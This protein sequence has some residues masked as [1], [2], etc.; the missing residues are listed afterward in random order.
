MHKNA[1][2]L[3]L[4]FLWTFL[5]ISAASAAVFDRQVMSSS[6]AMEMQTQAPTGRIVVKFTEE[7][8][9]LVS[10]NGL[11]GGKPGAVQRLSNLMAKQSTRG[12][13]QRRF[14]APMAQI[15]D[16]RRAGE[17]RIK[18]PLPNLNRYAVVDLSD[19]AGD[20]TQLL[21]VLKTIL[22]DPAVETA[23]LEPR[24]VPAAL[25]FDAFTGAYNPPSIPEA[26]ATVAGADS[27]FNTGFPASTNDFSSSQG[28]LGASPEGVNAW[29]VAD[30]PGA[31]GAGLHIIDIEG[32]WVWDHEDL[33]SPF[34]NPGS[35]MSAQSWRDHGTAVLGEI[36]GLDNGFGVR[37]I[38][39][40]VAIGGISI[41][42]FSVS[43]AINAAWRA[44]NP[45]DAIVIELHAPGPYSSG[46]G[47]DGYLPMEYWQDNFDAILIATANGR[48]VCEAA[49]NGAEDL[50]AP[51]YE[52][53]FDREY[54]DS[55]AIMCGAA[56]R[57]GV[58][59][60]FTNHGARVDLN[61]WG[62][63]VTTCAYGDLQGEPS[64]PETEFY[65]AHFSGTS[66]ATPIVT[67]AVLA[68]QG[69]VKEGSDSIL[70]PILM[71]EILVLTGSPSSGTKHCGPRPDILAAW[72][73]TA[74]GFGTVSGTV[75]DLVSGLP[76]AGAVVH[77]QGT[78]YDLVT[79]ENGDFSL[80]FLAGPMVLEIS[81]FFHESEVE[82]VE[83][84]AGDTTLLGLTLNPL[85]T[86]TV[87]GHVANSSGGELPGVRA[88][89][90]GAPLNAGE[91]SAEGNFSVEGAPVG[92]PFRLLVDNV[93]YFGADLIP[94]LPNS[95][96]KAEIF[97]DFHLTEA[98][99]HFEYFG[100]NY[101]DN[102][103][104]WTWGTPASGPAKGFSGDK[105]WGVGMAAEGY[106]DNTLASLES[107]QY[108]LYGSAQAQL[109]FH[110]WCD[111]EAGQDG[112][113][114]QVLHNNNWIDLQPES[115]YEY[116]RVSSL[117]GT[118][119][120]SGNSDGWRGAVFDLMPY[121]ENFVQ[122]RFFFGADNSLGDG[123]F[124]LDDITLSLDDV[125]SAVEMQPATAAALAPRVAVYP[126]P[127]N[128]QTEI[129]W[130]INSAGPLKIEVFDARGLLVR[131]LYD[132]P[133]SAVQ[134]V[135]VFDG[136]DE[137]GS[138][139]ASGMYLVRVQDGTGQEKTSRVCL[140]K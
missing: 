11:L 113:K 76:V 63:S 133:V 124:Y 54:R 116:D 40:A 25:G 34:Y 48:I 28:Y 24:A 114:L 64:F 121:I 84:L 44:V 128:P 22:A 46:E 111:T 62:S 110:Y 12:G 57:Y 127:F 50:D 1:I 15:D 77:P 18:H 80:G 71:R 72:T 104:V 98:V 134:G 117:N 94:V 7:S 81:S 115:D 31:N 74:I 56:N 93:P 73:E 43:G 125:L 106:P 21:L 23:F 140:V 138:R 51:G 39:P 58:P 32:A 79:D 13:F 78:N 49:G 129:A 83:V 107:I 131:R 52:P 99:H 68:L 89:V 3:V 97:L 41:Q 2:R 90:L 85:A 30:V 47:Q 6:K 59:E 132:G 88:T 112:V 102:T 92:R 82:N 69:I 103:G 130:E 65:T 126:N 135:Q 122:F 5:T 95:A 96:D 87:S 27:D 61:G 9:L 70:D 38:S 33:A 53:L 137:Q 36:A 101:L 105:C 66:S 60:W 55:G 17:N 29:A 108:N 10:E 139:L 123:G 14:P 8:Q 118:P 45:G 19:R 100:D 136:R 20:Q 91:I 120:W 75:T 86:V 119:G 67:G 35:M 42:S 16:E 4:P 109:S 37:G 26:M